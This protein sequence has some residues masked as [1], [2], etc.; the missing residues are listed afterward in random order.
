[1]AEPT[2]SLAA[3]L[4]RGLAV[5]PIPAGSKLAPGGWQ[6]RAS[7][8]PHQSWPQGSNI[9]VGCRASNLVVLDLDR[10]DGVDGVAA[11][12]ALAAERAQ[13][14]SDTFTVATGGGGL[15]LYFAAPAWTV[16]SSIG[17]FAAGVDVRAPGRTLGGY[18][19]G[20][21]SVV[22]GRP[23]TVA[24]DLPVR[25]LPGWIARRLRHQVP[26]LHRP[27]GPKTGHVRITRPS[28]DQERS[29]P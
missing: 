27:T 28:S 24:A 23:Y 22:E 4:A 5:F 9:G 14:W 2:I 3:L 29:R 7:A 25:A 16:V 1:M 19:V 12:A 20:P 17:T 18:V 13:P 10:K 26:G 11:L 15:H 8:D 6:A 21:G